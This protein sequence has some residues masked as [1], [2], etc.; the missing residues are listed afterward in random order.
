MLARCPTPGMRG[1]QLEASKV[2]AQLEA[3]KGAQVEA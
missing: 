1:A 3:I 2:G